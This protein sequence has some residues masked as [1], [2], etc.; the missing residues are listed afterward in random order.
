MYESPCFSTPLPTHYMISPFNFSHSIGVKWHSIILILYWTSFYRIIAYFYFVF[1]EIC[2]LILRIE[3]IVLFIGLYEF[4]ICCWF[5]CF[6]S[7]MCYEYF[8]LLYSLP[9]HF[10]EFLPWRADSLNFWGSPIYQ[11]FPYGYC[12]FLFPMF[13]SRRF[14][15]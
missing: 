15:S 8:L 12:F 5:K 7:Y 10:L 4:I 9:F 13:A 11:Y 14:I 2:S 3:L 1:Y 6:V